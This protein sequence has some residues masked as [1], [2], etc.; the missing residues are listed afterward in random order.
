MPEQMHFDFTPNDDGA[1]GT[2]VTNLTLTDGDPEHYPT[3]LAALDGS[4]TAA[5]LVAVDGLGAFTLHGATLTFTRAADSD[6][7]IELIANEIIA[8]LR[9]AFL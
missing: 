6:L 8:V 5:L 3:P 7:P 1:S 4:F 2:I 9:E